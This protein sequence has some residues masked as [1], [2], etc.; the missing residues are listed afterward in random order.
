MRPYSTDFRR[1]VVHAYERGA[2]SQ[3]ELARLC[4]VS[5]IFV[6]DLLRR[7]RQSGSVAPKPHGGGNP[8]KLGPYLSVVEQLHQ[9]RPDASLAERCEHLAATTPVHVGRSTRQRALKR[10]GLTRKK[11][12]S[13]PRSRT[14]KR[15]AKPAWPSRNSSGNRR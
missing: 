13:M 5:L 8:G 14:L 9:Q 11:R 2:G 1:K 7:Y 10:L 6:H 3:R 4:G 15:G 12:R